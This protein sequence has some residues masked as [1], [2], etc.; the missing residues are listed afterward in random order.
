MTVFTEKLAS[1]FGDKKWVSVDE[2]FRAYENKKIS[3]D[4]AWQ[5]VK[6]ANVPLPGKL[7]VAGTIRGLRGYAHP[8][9]AGLT[10]TGDLHLSRYD[11]PL[12][13]GLTT[14]GD[15]HLGRY[16]HPLPDGLTT[17][18][19][20]WLGGYA[21]PLPAGLTKTGGPARPCRLPTPITRRFDEDRGPGPLRL[22]PPIARRFD[23]DRGPIPNRI[24][25]R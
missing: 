9:P 15:L 17:T 3:W 20:L 7:T 6:N 14:T 11:H 12:P 16:D 19:D 13:A 18:G 24:S 23:D 2:L 5:A 22:R 8:L 4:D 21:H 25:K 10:T 1:A